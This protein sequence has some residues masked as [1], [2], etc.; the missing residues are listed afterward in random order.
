[1]LLGGGGHRLVHAI[2]L[3]DAQGHAAQTLAGL[4]GNLDAVLAVTLALAHGVDRLAGADL[5]LLDHVLHLLC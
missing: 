3:A 1:M 2:N 4:I 5:Q